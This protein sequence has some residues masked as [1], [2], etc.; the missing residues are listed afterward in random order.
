MDQLGMYQ[1]F[2]KRAKKFNT[3]VSFWCKRR[4]E[5]LGNDDITSVKRVKTENS[6]F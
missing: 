4:R 1:T 6:V 5:L 3:G 2:L